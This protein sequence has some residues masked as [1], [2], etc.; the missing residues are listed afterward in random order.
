[1]PLLLNQP[2][3]RTPVHAAM[4]EDYRFTIGGKHFC[5]DSNNLAL[6]KLDDPEEEV[7]LCPA[8]PQF[9]LHTPR[10]VMML[11]LESTN[12]CPLRCTYCNPA[13]T[14]ILMADMSYKPIEEVSA[15]D[16][17]IGWNFVVGSGKHTKFTV[18]EVVS[19][20]SRRS[21]LVD[22]VTDK[23]R[24]TCTPDHRW[25]HRKRYQRLAVGRKIGYVGGDREFR[26]PTED[27]KRGYLTGVFAGDGCLYEGQHLYKVDGKLRVVVH[28]R[29]LMQDREA[30]DRAYEYSQDLGLEMHR[31]EGK[32]CF[33]GYHG[34]RSGRKDVCSYLSSM[35]SNPSAEFKRGWLAGLW[36]AE[37]AS[38]KH[39]RC[40]RIYQNP[41][42][43]LDTAVSFL[44]DSGFVSRV[45][46]TSGKATKEIRVST[47]ISESLRFISW[48]QPA[49]SR[50]YQPVLV[51]KSV[52]ENATIES[53]E[54]A[55]EAEVYSL[56]T[57]TGNYVAHGMMSKNC[58]NEAYDNRS[59]KMSF[60]TARR[61][62]TGLLDKG[63]FAGSGSKRPVI[64]FFGGEPMANWELVEQIVP[65]VQGYFSPGPVGFSMTTNGVLIKPKHAE[66]MTEKGFSFIVSVDG[67]KHL[68]D[69]YRVYGN[70]SGSFDDTVRG[71]KT[72]VEAGSRK[73]TLRST[74]APGEEHILERVQFLNELC[75]QGFGSW[76]SVEPVCLTESHC[77][78]HDYGSISAYTVAA[79]AA[80]EEQYMEVAQWAIERYKAG[81]PVRFHNLVKPIERLLYTVHSPNECGAGNGYASVSHDGTIWACH[82]MNWGRIGHLEGGGISE[83]DRAIWSDSRLYQREGCISC[84]IRWA[85]GGGC[86]EASLGQN[87]DI[88]KPYKVSC[89]FMDTWVRI[90]AY[91]MAE[92]GPEKLKTVIPEPGKK[93]APVGNQQHSCGCQMSCQTEQ[94]RG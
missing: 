76:V 54:P 81:K 25:Y 49:I 77:V 12:A 8:K 68:H 58:F 43:V 67:P 39:T 80:T 48:C 75:D 20:A 9:Q 64:G 53:I 92:V 56:Q 6:W 3:F 18:G 13:G 73:I 84:P 70:G 24:F 72:L 51:G 59:A 11:V 61:A 33:L 40:V 30:V 29:L 31:Y 38:F 52:Y 66:F 50:K 19:V 74:F 69:K 60:D 15:G 7:A 42:P 34:L 55:G 86:R 45:V 47:T 14:P 44:N 28:C 4:Q 63:M 26:S 22:V 32:N 36:D 5:L 21:P 90:A 41:G 89:K 94:E 17:I 65:F 82:R 62:V 35:P 79:A 83:Q 46:D 1:M 57:T 91:V 78:K 23:G 16:K 88:R 85:C 87:R 37:G 2:R 10:G 93:K 27:Y 71:L